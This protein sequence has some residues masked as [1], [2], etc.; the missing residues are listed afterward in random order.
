MEVTL[1]STNSDPAGEWKPPLGIGD[2]TRFGRELRNHRGVIKGSLPIYSER[3]V[4][5]FNKYGI[6]DA[7]DPDRWT[8]LAFCLAMDYVPTFMLGPRPQGRKRSPTYFAL[9]AEVESAQLGTV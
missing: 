8:R 7:N 9:I 2:V 4:A 6:T 5:L 1:D 3:L